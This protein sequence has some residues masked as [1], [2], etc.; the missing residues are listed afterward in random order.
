MKLTMFLPFNPDLSWDLARQVGVTHAVVKLAPEL[1]GMNPPW[2]PDV[3]R[4]AK[5]RFNRAGLQLLGLEGDPFDMN[6]IKRGLP[7]CEEDFERYRSMLKYMGELELPLLCYNFMVGVGW[8]RNRTD[9]PER[10]GAVTSGFFQKYEP[11]QTEEIVSREAVWNNYVRF[12]EEVLPTAEQSGVQMGLHP[13]DPP[14]PSLQGFGRI[15][16]SAAGYRR[17]MALSSSRSHGITFCQSNF[18]AMGENVPNLIREWRDRIVFYH[19]RDIRGCAESFTETFHDNGEH[20]MRAVIATLKEIGYTGPVRTDHAPSM[21]GEGK[22]NGYKILGHLFAIGYL[23]GLWEGVPE[24][25]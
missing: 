13:D 10:G 1:T 22:A 18:Y 17:A 14:V 3:L 5:N 25:S 8:Y 12:I 23:K 24:I 6:R 19:F 4:E 9:I 21:G 11:E 7:G 20:D 16:G 15:F 2:E